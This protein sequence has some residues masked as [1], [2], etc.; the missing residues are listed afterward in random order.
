VGGGVP[1]NC[2]QQTAYLEAII[3]AVG[4]G[5]DF[6]F[7]ITTDRPDWGGISGCTFR[8]GVSWGK[9][10]DDREFVTCYSDA[11][12]ALPLIMRAVLEGLRT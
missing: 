11:T 7:Q 9:V 2:I 5:H 6:G 8:E 4:R 12:I 3:D 10:K 1:K